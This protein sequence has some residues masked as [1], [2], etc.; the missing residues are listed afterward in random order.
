MHSIR[1]EAYCPKPKKQVEK[2]NKTISSPKEKHTEEPAS[3][4][5][6]KLLTNT[7]HPGD[8]KGVNLTFETPY[9]KAPEASVNKGLNRTAA[10]KAYSLVGKSPSR[11]FV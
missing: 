9:K 2:M 3:S 11:R 8:Q 10:K 4:Q 7:N 6:E 5:P 1:E